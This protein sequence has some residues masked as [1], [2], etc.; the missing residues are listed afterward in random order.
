MACSHSSPR[1][2]RS[3]LIAGD[4]LRPT[5]V[6]KASA[7]SSLMEDLNRSPRLELLQGLEHPEIGVLSARP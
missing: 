5:V 3:M 1:L 6:V 4:S 7:A 2:M